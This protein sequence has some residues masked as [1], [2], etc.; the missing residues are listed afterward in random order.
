MCSSRSFSASSPPR[1]SKSQASSGRLALAEL[2]SGMPLCSTSKRDLKRDVT[3]K[4][5]KKI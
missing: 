4:K 3:K 2:P 1:P 5:K